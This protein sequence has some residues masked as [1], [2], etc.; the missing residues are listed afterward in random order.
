MS[1]AIISA[2]HAELDDARRILDRCMVRAS[3]MATFPGAGDK[4]R[5]GVGEPMPAPLVP[6]KP[7]GFLPGGRH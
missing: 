7:P 4:T 6:P 5:G 1:P 3:A 2:V